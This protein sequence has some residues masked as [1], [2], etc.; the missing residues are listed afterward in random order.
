VRTLA[1]SEAT[2]PVEVRDRAL[3]EAY[4]RRRPEAHLYALADLDDR[5]WPDTTWYARIERGEIRALALLLATLRVP[6]LYAVA[7]PRDPDTFALLESLGPVLPETFFVNL[8]S[9]LWPALG[10]RHRFTPHGVHL[11]MALREPAALHAVDT[12][13][14]EPI[15]PEHERELREF[16]AGAYG[17]EDGG[18][19]FFE[20]YMLRTGGYAGVRRGGKLICAGGAHVVSERFGVAAIGNLATAPGCRGRGL[21]RKVAAHVALRLLE[22][23]PL[24]GL[25]V[26][27]QNTAARRC[28]AALGFSPVL[29]YEEGIFEPS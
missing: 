16:Y 18:E 13:G 23:A 8:A 24:V 4:L 21:A 15:G 26:R 28:Y 27:A 12:A 3:L 29:S 22:R 2:A 25:N 19:R 5:F 9:G 1:W 6:I 17:P 11:K 20:A 7:P 14:V 10:A